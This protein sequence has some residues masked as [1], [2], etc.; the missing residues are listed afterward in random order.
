M[1]SL[2]LLLLTFIGALLEVVGV[3]AVLPLVQLMIDPERFGSNELAKKLAAFAGIE[4]YGQ[5]VLL[6]AMGVIFVYFVKNL[7][8]TI[9]SYIRV[10]FA[11]SV[12]KELGIRIMKIYMGQGYLFFTRNNTNDMYREITVDVEGVYNS[13]N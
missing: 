2:L 12:Q 3:S 1:L 6:T 10:K 8:L 4:C 5:L 9:L 7:Y 13:V 11:A